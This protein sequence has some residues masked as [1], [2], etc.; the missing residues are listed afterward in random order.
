MSPQE[1]AIADATIR[2]IV[3]QGFD[4]VSV[5]KVAAEAAVAP[6]T[7]QYFMGTRDDLLKKALLRSVTRQEQRV[8]ALNI[9]P[10]AHPLDRLSRALLELL[11]TGAI[12]REDAALWVI[13]GAASSTR[14]WL[15]GLYQQQLHTFQQ[16][17]ATLL[18]TPATT[19]A[20]QTARL[21]TALVNGLT[22]DYL[23]APTTEESTKRLTQDLLSGLNRLL[24]SPSDKPAPAH[25]RE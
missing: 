20:N 8:A 12:Q 23:N 6:G 16:R 19:S 22:L 13:L 10:S 17:V 3:N 1:V 24:S 2:V 21:I 11:P 18:E 14:S 5:R 4:V 9:P 25:P 7:V 15:A